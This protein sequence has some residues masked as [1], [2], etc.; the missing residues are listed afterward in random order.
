MFR[1]VELSYE[2]WYD[3]KTFDLRVL[4]DQR[5]PG[6]KKADAKELRNKYQTNPNYIDA[7]SNVRI[8]KVRR[9]APWWHNR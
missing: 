1:R 9:T 4:T 3:L 2:V 6:L 8:I 5:T 7:Y